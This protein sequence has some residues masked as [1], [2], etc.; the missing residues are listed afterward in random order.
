MKFFTTNEIKPTGWLKRQLEIQANGLSGNLDKIWN[1]IKNSAWVGG[2]CE[3]WERVPYWLDGFI[4]LAYLLD[5]EDMKC[6][7]KKYVD[8]IL[9]N[10]KADGWICPCSDEEQGRYDVW[11]CF[12]ICK[13]LVLYADCSGDERIESAV[14][15]ALKNLNKHIRTHTLFDWGS[16]RWF[17]CLIPIIWLYERNPE[18]WMLDLV[19][20]LQVQGID[21]E[22]VYNNWRYAERRDS[23]SFIN[24]VVNT[25]MMLK[26]SALM[27]YFDGGNPNE[28]AKKAM[29]ILLRDHGMACGHFTGDE[30]LSGLSPIHGS[31][32]CSVAEAMYS[33]EWL[34]ALTED[35]Y[36]SERLEMTAF[37]AFPATVSPDM[38]THQYDQMTNQ[39][40]CVRFPDG[41]QPFDTNGEESHLFGLE[42]NYGCCTANFNQA[43]PKFALSVFMKTNNGFAVAA[44][45]PSKLKTESC[46]AEL[47]TDYPFD[48]GYILKIKSDTHENFDVVL[49]IPENAVNPTVNGEK[50]ESGFYKISK[51]WYGE[52][53]IKVDFSFET[54]LVERPNDM[55]CVQRGNL[56]FALPVGERWEKREYTDNGVER[57]FPYCDYEIFPTTKWSYA[58]ANS[59]FEVV[60]SN[61][62]DFPFSPDGAPLRIKAEA[63]PVKWEIHHGA[64]TEKPESLNPEGEAETIELI[65][66]GCTNLRV[67]EMPYIR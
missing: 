40:Q 65:P 58:L 30:C 54:K 16:S 15:G 51:D 20:K 8:A 44:I 53:Q 10:Q 67:T 5:D 60:K 61:I 36:W 25:A 43:F 12:L 45:A 66:Y 27:S 11:A 28:F 47:V 57:K 32:C 41:K 22:K 46:S 6:R 1:D 48:D 14:S 7:A 17:E 4:P 55:Y 21:Y 50:A 33:Y 38:W 63:V 42:P 37:N 62:K 35:S 39:V 29:E 23:W 64:C 34:V 24:H 31:E 19:Q 9:A 3:G 52:T 49:R 18:D 2:D 56:V 13:A 59:R 26:S